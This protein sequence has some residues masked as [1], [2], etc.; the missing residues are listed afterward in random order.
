LIGLSQS[1]AIKLIP[2]LQGKLVRLADDSVTV[3]PRI[4]LRME[5]LMPQTRLS[6][7]KK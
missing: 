1:D 6:K 7:A 4:M 3:T 2:G 5:A